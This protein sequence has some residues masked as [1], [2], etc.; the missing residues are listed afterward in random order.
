MIDIDAYHFEKFDANK[1][2]FLK[3]YRT[4]LGNVSIASKSI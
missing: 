3:N 1:K 2:A 4:F